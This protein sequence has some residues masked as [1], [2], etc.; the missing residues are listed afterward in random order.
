MNKNIHDKTST[1]SE[2]DSDETLLE[3]VFEKF[4][5]NGKMGVKD[6]LKF[7]DDLKGIVPEVENVNRSEA[8]ALFYYLA[9]VNE[10][11]LST[12]KEWWSSPNKYD[13][14]INVDKTEL[15]TK[16]W[17]LYKKY[18]NRFGLIDS[19]NFRNLMEDLKIKG[20][21]GEFESLDMNADNTIDFK[22]F[23]KWLKWF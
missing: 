19:G 18:N 5:K 2:G 13:L 1:S 14:F 12:F 8:K 16:A 21:G 9:E 22:E 11:D 20:K 17:T 4:S 10:I 6:F 23:C 7:V 3:T 15:L